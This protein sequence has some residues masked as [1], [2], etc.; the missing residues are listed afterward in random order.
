MAGNF[1]LHK[2]NFVGYFHPAG[3]SIEKFRPW[4][5]FLNEHPFLSNS[6]R[7]D[8]Q[9]KI[10]PLHLVCTTSEINNNV[11]KFIIKDIEYTIDE[12]VV[13]RVL[14][15]PQDNFVPFPTDVELT[16][17]FNNINYQGAITLTKL[18]KSNLVIE[19]DCFFDTLAK[20]FSN[21]G[22][23]GFFNISTLLQNIAYAVV[24]NRRVNIAQ[25]V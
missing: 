23:K 13:S 15:F 8:A 5:Q 6:M 3:C 21:T 9:L 11:V 10:A 14:G 2:H 25:L 18:F 17:F 20:V 4:I 22:K 16:N 24:F 1:S 19:W 12:S 7:L